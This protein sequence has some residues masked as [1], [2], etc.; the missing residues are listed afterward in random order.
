MQPATLRKWLRQSR[1][2]NLASNFALIC[3]LNF[4]SPPKNREKSPASAIVPT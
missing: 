1:L 2:F 4:R 3:I